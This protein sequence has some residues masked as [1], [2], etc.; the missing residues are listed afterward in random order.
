M[1]PEHLACLQGTVAGTSPS[2]LRSHP[3]L[4]TLG[5]ANLT[6]MQAWPRSAHT[7]SSHDSRVACIRARDRPAIA[8]PLTVAALAGAAAAL[9][10]KLVISQLHSS[11]KH[12]W[13]HSSTAAR[14]PSQA[15]TCLVHMACKVHCL[16]AGWTQRCSADWTGPRGAAT[17]PLAGV[18]V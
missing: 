5:M 15:N 14:L 8:Q 12:L 9:G 13:L 18:L 16:P 11:C 4:R 6:Q 17:R 7:R 2:V 1:Q 10:R 3:Q